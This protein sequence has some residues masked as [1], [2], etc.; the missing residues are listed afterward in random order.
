MTY[1]QARRFVGKYV[2]WETDAKVGDVNDT[3]PPGGTLPVLV[4][5]V[6]LAGIVLETTSPVT[7]KST[8][9][10]TIPLERMTAMTERL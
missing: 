10:V 4:K 8:G 1:E 9:P 5:E 3:I 2:A 7:G 6:T